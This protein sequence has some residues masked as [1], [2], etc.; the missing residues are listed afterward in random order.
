MSK[1]QNGRNSGASATVVTTVVVTTV[2]V[3]TV[4][5]TTPLRE[6]TQSNTKE[7]RAARLTDVNQQHTTTQSNTKQHN[8]PRFRR[9]PATRRRLATRRE[10]IPQRDVSGASLRDGGGGAG[11]PLTLV[12]GCGRVLG[13]AGDAIH[14][15]F[16][17]KMGEIPLSEL[18]GW[19]VGWRR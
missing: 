11:W 19:L 9:H 17:P 2:V 6:T 7:H 1:L 15:T 18:V 16:R 4:T 5:A 10:V 3:T 13:N 12:T 8:A 14:L